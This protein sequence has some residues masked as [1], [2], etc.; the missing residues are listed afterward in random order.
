VPLRPHCR[1]RPPITPP[2]DHRTSRS[3]LRRKQPRPAASPI[4]TPGCV[5]RPL[6][7]LDRSTVSG[8]SAVRSA[9]QWSMPAR[10]GGPIQQGV[11]VREPPVGQRGGPAGPGSGSTRRTGPTTKR[12]RAGD[13]AQETGSLS[14]PEDRHRSEEDHLRAASTERSGTGRRHEQQER[15]EHGG[16]LPAPG[17]V[18]TAHTS[19]NSGPPPAQAPAGPSSERTTDDLAAAP[20]AAPGGREGGSSS[21]CPAAGGAFAQ[22]PPG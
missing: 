18:T 8:R 16:S 22:E 5:V 1:C 13:P 6:G 12:P 9:I 15:R 11:L 2:A 17:P 3:P 21:V 14:T 10:P 4:A 19:P 7:P 20:A